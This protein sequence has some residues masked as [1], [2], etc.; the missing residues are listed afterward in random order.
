MIKI[1]SIKPHFKKGYE[2]ELQKDNEIPKSV[3][4]PNQKLM[5]AWLEQTEQINE[6]SHYYENRSWYERTQELKK[7][8]YKQQTLF[9]E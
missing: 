4:C 2:V 7:Q 9:P 8:L 3:W 6:F 5:D 1:L